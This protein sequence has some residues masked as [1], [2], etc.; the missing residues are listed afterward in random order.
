MLFDKSSESI[1]D[2]PTANSLSG[3]QPVYELKDFC[4]DI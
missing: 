2:F 1:S 3:Q 4:Y